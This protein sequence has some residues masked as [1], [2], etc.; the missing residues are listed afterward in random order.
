MTRKRIAIG[1]FDEDWRLFV[2]PG[3]WVAT[4]GRS[5]LYP[6]S[7]STPIDEASISLIFRKVP[8]MN[9]CMVAGLNE[10]RVLPNS[11][12]FQ[13]S[14]VKPA[15]YARQPKNKASKTPHAN[16][17]G[18]RRSW[19][20]IASHQLCIIFRTGTY[21]PIQINIVKN[22]PGL[23]VCWCQ[24]SRMPRRRLFWNLS[25]TTS[26]NMAVMD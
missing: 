12:N 6:R 11:G 24:M 4:R 1:E 7:V 19:E 14:W 23:L 8:I 13:T 25:G 21:F 5:K 10:G 15:P 9:R 2:I 22:R 17:R 26:V 16:W 18:R 20:P 3:F